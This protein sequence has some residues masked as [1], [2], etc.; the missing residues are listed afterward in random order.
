[1]AGR[2]IGIQSTLIDITERKKAEETLRHRL[3]IEQLAAS[4]STEFLTLAHDE[5]EAGIISA[6]ERVGKFV[7]A[8]RGFLLQLA[9]DRNSLRVTHHWHAP[10]VEPIKERSEAPSAESLRWW[11]DKLNAEKFLVVRSTDELPDSVEA[12]RG[13]Y[14]S[15]GTRSRLAVPLRLQGEVIGSLNFSSVSEERDWPIEDIRMLNVIGEVFINALEQKRKTEE[16]VRVNQERL[17]QERQIAGGFA[18]ELRNALFPAR[19]MLDKLLNP[20]EESMIVEDRETYS[21]LIEASLNRASDIVGAILSYTRLGSQTK[22]EGVKIGEV[23]R[24]VLEANKLPLE[25]MMVR[26]AVVGDEGLTVRSNC[27]QLF[28]VIN[29]IVINALDA[30]ETVAIPELKL[31]WGEADGQGVL[32]ISDNGSG[33]SL[34]TRTKLFEPF[35]STKPDKGTGLG[36]ATAQKIVALYDGSLEVESLPDQGSTFIVKHWLHV[37]FNG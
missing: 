36:L 18:H 23:V 6:L 16:V 12:E 25:S 22:E 34:E 19:N 14:E 17:A 1:M 31:A 21:R 4:I 33:M 26:V 27:K 24:E 2:V 37:P 8:E 11:I 9:A 15:A 35:Y 29:N 20:S 5:I 3:E 28:T 30:M 13:F 10:G 7:R 32:K